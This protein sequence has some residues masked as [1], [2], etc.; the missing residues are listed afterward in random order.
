MWCLGV[1]EAVQDINDSRTQVYK[2][3]SNLGEAYLS[4]TGDTVIHE[5]T[6]S[7]LI[8]GTPGPIPRRTPGWTHMDKVSI[9]S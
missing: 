9:L 5:W 7:P 2:V 3:D 6:K 1:H 8:V 4:G